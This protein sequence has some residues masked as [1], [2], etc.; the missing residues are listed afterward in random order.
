[1]IHKYIARIRLQSS[2]KLRDYL[3]AH[4]QIRL[5]D[6]FFMDDRKE[7]LVFTKHN[8]LSDRFGFSDGTK[9]VRGTISQHD[10]IKFNDYVEIRRK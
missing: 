9:G 10:T 4:G 8:Q 2:I 1:M 3:E 5:S 6:E 7:F